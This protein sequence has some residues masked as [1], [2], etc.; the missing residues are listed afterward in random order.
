MR[1][2]LPLFRGVPRGRRCATEIALRQQRADFVH[3][4]HGLLSTLHIGAER[5]GLGLDDF[6]K[7]GG[8][9]GNDGFR[10]RAVAAMQVDNQI[11]NAGEH[12]G[13]VEH[14]AVV[15]SYGL[16]LRAQAITLSS[17]SDPRKG[18]TKRATWN[19]SLGR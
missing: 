11:S 9:F 3:G 12:V 5:I 4:K 13:R 19:F 17:R 8:H 6:L 7:V 16:W 15:F 2:L 10:L 1:E 18:E 14:F